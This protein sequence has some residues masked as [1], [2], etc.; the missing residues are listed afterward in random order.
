M[1]RRFWQ[2]AALVLT[3]VAFSGSP[4]RA[5]WGFPG[6]FGGFGWEGWGVG[7]V[8]GDEARGLGMFAAGL[9]TYNLQTAKADSIDADTVMRW[10]EY[11]YQSQRSADVRRRERA[12]RRLARNSQQAEATQSR[13]RDNPTTADIFSGDALN[14]ALSEINDPRVYAKALEGGKT[15]IGGDKV[16]IIPFRYNAAAIT[17][18]VHQLATGEFPAGLRRPEFDSD[19][20]ALKS[21][22]EEIT[23]QVEKDQEPDPATVKKLLGAIYAAEE[24]A[25][26]VLPANS[27][28]LK[29]A[30]KYLKALHGL[31]AM[32]K[33][34]S[35]DTYLAGVENRP[36]TSVGE[37]L[38]FMNAFNLRFGAATTP[39][40]REVYT[41]LYPSLDALRDQVA[42]ALAAEA[43]RRT[44]G[45]A[46]Q[47]FFSRMSFSDLGKSAPKP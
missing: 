15:R 5:Q 16:R 1:N 24:K 3:F 39:R 37:L 26:Q 20:Q 43:P 7:T 22:D 11:L 2:P 42:P 9:G 46:V 36:E 38:E 35:L 18:S 41:A 17:L 40:Q 47:D 44:L 31:V 30:Q 8:A 13:L 25:V 28:E 34:P 19:R 10:N 23:A 14:V 45:G 29:Q 12:D 4:A 27:L 21:I 33:T 32:L 6:G